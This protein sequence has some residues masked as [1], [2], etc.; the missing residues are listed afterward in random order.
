MQE[1]GS[2]AGIR[3]MDTVVLQNGGPAS[4]SVGT[5]AVQDGGPASGGGGSGQAVG[6]GA[7]GCGWVRR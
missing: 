3:G 7:Q 6:G 4:G 2:G 1:G 5:V